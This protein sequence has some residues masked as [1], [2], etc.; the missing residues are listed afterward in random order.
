MKKTFIYWLCCMSMLLSIG[1]AACVGSAKKNVSDNFIH[2][3]IN[4]L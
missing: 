1:L 3:K 2:S 4:Q